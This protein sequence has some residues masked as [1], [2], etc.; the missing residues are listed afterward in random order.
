MTLDFEPFIILTKGVSLH[1]YIKVP[2]KLGERYCRCGGGRWTIENDDTLKLYDESADF[3]KYDAKYTQEA[4]D[5]H[6]VYY[7]E[8]PVFDE[9]EIKKLIM[10]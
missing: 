9:I 7:F 6:N 10:V 1:R 4:F 3:G 2:A 8:E 5:K